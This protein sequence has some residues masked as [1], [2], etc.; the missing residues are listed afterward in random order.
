MCG[1][2]DI[3]GNH[4][5]ASPSEYSQAQPGRGTSLDGESNL[6][7]LYHSF[8][9]SPERRD[10]APLNVNRR[11]SHPGQS[12]PSSVYIYA[13]LESTP[14]AVPNALIPSSPPTCGEVCILSNHE[15]PTE[16]PVVIRKLVTPCSLEVS[17]RMLHVFRI[18]LSFRNCRLPLRALPVPGTMVMA[19]FSCSREIYSRVVS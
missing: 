8:A 2:C 18:Q 12:V 3:R 15:E 19:L 16:T 1:P 14:N 6:K 17:C 11:P 10:A 7:T 13:P 4:A 5:M 9:P